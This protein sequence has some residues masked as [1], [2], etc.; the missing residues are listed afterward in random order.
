FPYL[1][2]HSAA[3]L[4]PGE[5]D[6]ELAYK[7]EADAAIEGPLGLQLQTQSGRSVPGTIA[8]DWS[9]SLHRSM[10]SIATKVLTPA[11]SGVEDKVLLV[12]LPA[13]RNP[14]D[15]LSR[16]ETRVLVELLRA[17]QQNLGRGRDLSDLRA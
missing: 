1:P 5:R 10:G 13:W 2:R 11:A 15:E 6:I 9:R 3:A 4:G 17:Q 16:R 14:L 7:F 12:H 8:V